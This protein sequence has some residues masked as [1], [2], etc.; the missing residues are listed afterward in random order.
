MQP[1]SVRRSRVSQQYRDSTPCLQA[2]CLD[3]KTPALSDIQRYH[4]NIPVRNALDLSPTLTIDQDA[5]A[6]DIV[7]CL[8]GDPCPEPPAPPPGTQTPVDQAETPATGPG[9]APPGGLPGTSAAPPPVTVPV[10][11]GSPVSPPVVPLTAEGLESSSAEPSGP[12]GVGRVAFCLV[13]VTAVA[14]LAPALLG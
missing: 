10:P 2:K 12:A 11:P 7:V 9:V 4:D 5:I 1:T 3:A 6:P 14:A 13:A 8:D